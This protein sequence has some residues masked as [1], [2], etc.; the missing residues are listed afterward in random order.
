M[1]RDNAAL[2]L[3]LHVISSPEFSVACL[4]LAFTA[5]ISKSYRLIG[6]CLASCRAYTFAHTRARAR[7]QT[8]PA[9]KLVVVYAI[10]TCVLLALAEHQTPS[11]TVVDRVKATTKAASIAVVLSF[12]TGVVTPKVARRS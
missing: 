11:L 5:T 7:T 8:V 6:A 9:I 4:V 3:A 1:D 12:L 10:F 2:R